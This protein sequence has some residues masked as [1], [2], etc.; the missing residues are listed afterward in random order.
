MPDTLPPFD[1]LILAGGRSSRLG[2]VPKQG[3]VFDGVTLLDRA[4]LAA[5]GARRTVVVGPEPGRLPDG[6]ICC[7]EQPEF[8]GPAAAIATGLGALGP[9]PAPYTLVLACDMPLASGAVNIIK[10]FLP[11]EPLP[12]SAPEALVACSADADGQG[13]AQPLAAFYGTAVL[14]KSARELAAAG[15]LVNGSVRSLLASLDVQLVPVPAAFT[16]DVDTWDDAAALGIAGRQ[17]VQGQ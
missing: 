10:Q 3:L 5:A 8:A 12:E 7:R 17:D 6:V 4:L 11:V 1:A 14:D 16:A 13:K 9:D 2:G 15:R